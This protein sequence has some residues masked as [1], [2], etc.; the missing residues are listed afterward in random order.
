ML[1]LLQWA[2]IRVPLGGGK[3]KQTLHESKMQGV[4]IRL[5]DYTKQ[6]GLKAKVGG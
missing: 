4:K 2:T 3:N 5:R 6:W 1:P